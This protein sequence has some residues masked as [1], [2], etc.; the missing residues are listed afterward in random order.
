MIYPNSTPEFRI[1]IDKDNVSQLQVRYINVAQG[2]AGV[3][4]AVEIVYE[5]DKNNNSKA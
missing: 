5:N 3:W 4:K 2:Y 1:F